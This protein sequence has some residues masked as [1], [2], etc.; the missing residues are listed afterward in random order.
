MTVMNRAGRTAI[1]CAALLLCFSQAAGARGEVP[2]PNSV[3]QVLQENG[4]P[5]IS[6]AVQD[7]SR[8]LFEQGFG[9]KNIDSQAPVDAHTRFEIGSITKQFTAAAILQLQERGKL[10][11]SDTLGKYVP[12]YKPGNKITIRQLLN[13]VSGIPDYTD[14]PQFMKIATFKRGTLDAVIAL[15]AGKP[16]EFAPGTRWQYSNTNYYLLGHVVE[17]ASGM[18][19]QTYIRTHIFA[20]AGMTESSFMEDERALPDMATGYMPGKKQKFVPSPPFGGWAYAAGAIVS[21]TG[22]LLK[23]DRALLGG[24]IISRRDL[25]EM[26]RSGHLN[27]GRLTGYGFGWMITRRDGTPEIWHN[28]GTFGFSAE[29]EVFPKLGQSIVVLENVSDGLNLAVAQS[30]FAAVNPGLAKLETQ[31]AAGEDPAV[32]ARAKSIW[33]ML[34]SGNVDRSQFSAAASKALTPQVVAAASQQLKMLGTG[35]TWAYSGL[36]QASG[37]NTYSY[38]VTFSTGLKLTVYMT[39]DGDGKIT[40][41]FFNQ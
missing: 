25:D 12:R 20:P 26:I 17:I 37:H 23:W 38:R 6:L 2:L 24:K 1:W 35:R 5:G 10:S 29:N 34:V 30:I 22:D 32:T 33:Q 19:W 14:A 36:T 21:T 8:V 3:L 16:L 9:V 15:I 13:Q 28:G 4:A 31:S 41:Y 27:S 7:R 18:P 11:L 40:S 39:V